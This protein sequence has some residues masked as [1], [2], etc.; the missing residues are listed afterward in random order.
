M[1]LVSRPQRVSEIKAK[2]KAKMFQDIEV[3]D[4]ITFELTLKNTTGAS[5]GGIYATNVLV[6]N[7][8]KKQSVWKTQNE[9]SNIIER[10]FTFEE[11]WEE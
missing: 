7:V 9:I 4:V 2:T 10:C 5:N 6:K 11:V 3:G 1:K 8:T